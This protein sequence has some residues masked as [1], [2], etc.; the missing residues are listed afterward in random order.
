MHD[1]NIEQTIDMYY[2]ALPPTTHHGVS[3]E[4]HD[5]AGHT[6]VRHRQ[7]DDEVV[8]DVLQGALPSHGQDHLQYVIWV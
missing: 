2:W 1:Q 3:V 4:G 8:G 5:D 7:G 6:E